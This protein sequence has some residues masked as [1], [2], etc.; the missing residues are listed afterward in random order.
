MS[1]ESELVITENS[2][3]NVSYGA[4]AVVAMAVIGFA[5]WLS[6][7]SETALANGH[8]IRK[9]ENNKDTQLMLLRETNTRLSRIEGYL[10]AVLPPAEKK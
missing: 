8:S 2:L 10:Q 1:D 7:I 5:L 9:L 4:L 6:S 3:L